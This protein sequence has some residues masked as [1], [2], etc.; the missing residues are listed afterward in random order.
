MTAGRRPLTAVEPLGD[1]P[2][3]S[4]STSRASSRAVCTSGII[5][6]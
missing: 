4:G 5:I 6:G 2:G 1:K 3:M